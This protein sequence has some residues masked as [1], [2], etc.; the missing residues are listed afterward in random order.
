MGKS[1]FRFKQFLIKQESAAMKVGTDGV[2][3][4]AWIDAEGVNS[5]LDIGTGSGVIALM[6]AQRNHNATIH[7]VEIDHSSALQ[8]KYNFENSPWSSRLRIDPLPLQEFSSKCDSKFD[9]IVSNP[10]YFNKS[11]KSPSPERTLSRHTDELPNS[12][13][14]EGV[15]KHLVADGRFCAIFPYTEGNIFIAEAVNYG[16]YCNRKLFVKTKPEKPV[17]RILTEFSFHKKLLPDSTISIHTI[18]GDYTE[19]YKMLTADFYLAF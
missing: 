11:L 15:K 13:L 12:D 7:A 2:L 9:L 3:L 16:L 8:A 18:E 6:I 5:V 10:P 17:I 14:L 19:E 4:G 1:Y